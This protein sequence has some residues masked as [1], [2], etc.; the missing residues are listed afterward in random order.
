MERTFPN[1]GVFVGP[2]DSHVDVLKLRFC[3][4]FCSFEGSLG[5]LYVERTFPNLRVFVCPLESHVILLRGF[6]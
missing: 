6:V 3:V 5:G 1:L 4:S 2:L